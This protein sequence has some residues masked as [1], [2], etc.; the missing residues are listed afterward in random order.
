M[1]LSLELNSNNNE[2]I[3]KVPKSRDLPIQFQ[4]IMA[5]HL[6]SCQFI[7]HCNLRI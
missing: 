6:H 1:I 3:L 7:G 4:K 5:N 2:N